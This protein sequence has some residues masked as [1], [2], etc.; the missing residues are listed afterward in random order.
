MKTTEPIRDKRRI[1]ELADYYLKRA[2]IR[3]Y[4][5][6]VMGLYTAL[7]ISDLLR[8]CWEDVY[9]F[10]NKRVRRSITLV[11]K[12]TG[13][14]K[15]IALNDRAVAA[16][17]LFCNAARE[18]AFIIENKR[19][20][21]AISRVQAHRIIRAASDALDFRENVSCHSLRKTFGYHA[22]QSGVSLALIMEIFNDSSITVTRRYLGVTQDDINGV[23]LSL[24]LIA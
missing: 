1:R 12:K 4:V 21:K 22:W 10:D 3:N 19:T 17:S 11:E 18:G 6:I 14:S 2:Q 9:D 23:Y 24:S 5:L 15:T 13:K 16:L 8:L 20:G 7:R